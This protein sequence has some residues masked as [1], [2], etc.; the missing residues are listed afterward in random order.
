MTKRRII[1]ATISA[2][3][4]FGAAGGTVAAATASAAPAVASA[5]QMHYFG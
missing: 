3:A 5:P 4:I 2:L 1:A